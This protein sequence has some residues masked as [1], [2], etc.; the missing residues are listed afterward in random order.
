MSPYYF[1]RLFKQ[2]TG[3]SPHQFLLRRRIERAKEC[4]PLPGAGSRR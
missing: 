4:W 1:T 2:S 3:L